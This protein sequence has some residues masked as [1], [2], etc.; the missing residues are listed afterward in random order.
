MNLRILLT[1][2]LLLTPVATRATASLPDGWV[3]WSTPAID[4]APAYCCFDWEQRTESAQTCALDREPRGFGNRDGQTTTTLQVYARFENRQLRAVRS[5]GD[6]CVVDQQQVVQDLGKLSIDASLDLLQR[7]L[8]EGTAAADMRLLTIALH[9]GK[10]ALDWMVAQAFAGPA[11][12]REQ[13]LFWL[14]HA[15]ARDAVVSLKRALFDDPLASF[16]SHA[17]F[18]VSQS[19]LAERSDWLKSAASRDHDA[20]V[21]QQAWFWFA[22]SE[23]AAARDDL[24]K[25]L[26]VEKNEAVREHIVFAISQLPA[27]AGLDTLITMIDNR[28]LD[29]DLRKRALFWVAQSADPRATEVMDQRLR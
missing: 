24:L 5:F 23:G 26:D 15:R 16:R 12:S 17:A 1:L 6:T 8:P 18:V 13:A 9:R 3:R 25:A 2:L 10:R 22:Q 28:A 20:E 21:R 4:D 29:R 7:P 14:G 27:P 19:P 11:K